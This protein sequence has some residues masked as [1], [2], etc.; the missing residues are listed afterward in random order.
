MQHAVAGQAEDVVDAV[1][2][3][4]RHGL[5]PSVVGIS[6]EGEPGARPVPADAAHQVLEEGPDLGARRRLAGAQENRHRLAA[7]DVVDV[8]RQEAAGVVV[9]M[10]QRQLLVAVHRIAGIVDVERDRRGRGGEAAAEEIDQRRRHARHLD[11]RGRVLQ[12]AHGRLRAQRAAAL[13][14]PAD[15]QLEQR[16][17]T[18]G[19]A[20]VGILVSAGDREHAE[21]QHRR[22]RVHHQRRI[23]PFPDAARQRLGQAK[24]AFGPAQ[25]DQPAVRRDQPAPEIGGHLLAFDGWKIERELAIFGHGGRGAFVAWG[26]GR[27]T[28]TFYPI[29]TTYAMSAI[30][31]LGR[32]E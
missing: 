25:Q 7:L 4:P 22:Q 8:D 18:Q 30:I 24:P 12:P 16:I 14:R 10:E 31:T 23:A 13:R 21:A 26:E 1:V 11:A 20:V 28:T 15:G 9:G 6:P 27:W 19:V 5:G 3:A 32:A 2:L 29:P 17:G